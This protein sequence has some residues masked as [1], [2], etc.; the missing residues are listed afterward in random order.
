[1]RYITPIVHLWKYIDYFSNLDWFG[2]K[3]SIDVVILD[4][5]VNRSSGEFKWIITVE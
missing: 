3:N 1:M 2:K 5:N 4:D